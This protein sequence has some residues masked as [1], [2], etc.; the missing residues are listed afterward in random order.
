MRKA[1]RLK[2]QKAKKEKEESEVATPVY[3]DG[4]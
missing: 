4:L 1:L 3:S 2:R